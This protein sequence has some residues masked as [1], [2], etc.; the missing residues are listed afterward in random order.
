MCEHV[1]VRGPRYTEQ[2]ARAAVA[3]SR[4]YNE[5]LRRLGMRT[6]GGNHRTIRHYVEEVWQIPR[7]HF[8]PQAANIAARLRRAGTPL[9]E[10]LVEG[11]SYQRG[12][13]KERL[14]ES[15][16]KLPLCELCGQDE[17]WNGRRMSLILDHVNGVAN[18]NRLQNLRIVCANCAATLPTHCGRNKPVAEPRQCALCGEFFR[19]K[20]AEQRYCSGTCASRGPSSRAPRPAARSVARPASETLLAEVARLGYKAVGRRY[21]VSDNA[22][23][24]WL[25][26]EGIEPPRRI[27]SKRSGFARG[28]TS[29]TEPARTRGS[30][31]RSSP[32][33]ARAP[34]AS[35]RSR[36]RGS[37][38]LRASRRPRR[39]RRS[40]RRSRRGGR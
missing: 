27:R 25:R 8:D 1:F 28:P 4:S 7:D 15:G 35:S 2:E 9:E 22:I 40:R 10:I 20:T 14:Y 31:R 21:G 11:S 18:D 38:A 13:L 6:A 30:P 16:I 33:K 3:E 39:P 34:P 32:R 12:H 19:P 37:R 17:V 5:V 23:R 36:R 26:V 29:E 24:K